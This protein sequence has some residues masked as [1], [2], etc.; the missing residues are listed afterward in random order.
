MAFTELVLGF[1]RP[2][3]IGSAAFFALLL[4]IRFGTPRR[5]PAVITRRHSR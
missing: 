2:V 1:L 3:G 4:A 5:T